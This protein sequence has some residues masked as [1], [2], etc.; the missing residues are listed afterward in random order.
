V[1]VSMATPIACPRW[2]AATLRVH[3]LLMAEAGLSSAQHL[4]VDPTEADLLKLSLN[5][6]P[7]EIV[8]RQ[9]RAPFRRKHQRIRTRI[10]RDLTPGIDILRKIGGQ[11]S[12]PFPPPAFRGYSRSRSNFRMKSTNWTPDI[13][14]TR[15]SSSKSSRRAP[16]S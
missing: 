8:T 7:Q 1:Y 5:V 11:S 13:S 16:D 15:R 6:P 4:K 9:V 14:Q 2:S 10:R 12:L 3:A